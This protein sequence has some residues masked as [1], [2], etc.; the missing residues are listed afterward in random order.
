MAREAIL[1][2]KLRKLR[3]EKIM[4]KV[5]REEIMEA[6]AHT[7]HIDHGIEIITEKFDV[8]EEEARFLILKSIDML[9]S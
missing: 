9:D 2:M 3:K 6:I 5:T 1:Y 7:K 8:S 4:E